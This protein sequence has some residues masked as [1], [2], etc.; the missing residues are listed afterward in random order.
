MFLVLLGLE[1]LELLHISITDLARR[2]ESLTTRPQ[3]KTSHWMQC[4]S[5]HRMQVTD[6]SRSSGVLVADC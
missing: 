4:H 3:A 2:K 5:I 1:R 6:M